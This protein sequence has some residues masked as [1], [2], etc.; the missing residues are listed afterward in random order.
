MADI[1]VS[2]ILILFLLIFPILR[3]FFKFLKKMPAVSLLPFFAIILGILLVFGQGL[4]VSILPVLIFSVLVFFSEIKRIVRFFAGLTNEFYSVVSIVFRAFL[5]ILWGLVFFEIVKFSPENAYAVT[6]KVETREVIL[7]DSFGKECFGGFFAQPDNSNVENLPTVLVMPSFKHTTSDISTVARY[8]IQEKYPVI[9]IRDICK[10]QP[11]YVPRGLDSLKNVFQLLLGNSDIEYIDEPEFEGFIDAVLE[12]YAS[13]KAVFVFSEGV[14]NKLITDYAIK[15][16][17]KIAGTF[18][19]AS[20]EYANKILQDI[21]ENRSIRMSADE[22]AKF[23]PEVALKPVCLFV[24]S[25]K[26]NLADMSELRGDDPLAAV[27]LGSSRSIGRSDLI[28]PAKVF[29][30]WIYVRGNYETK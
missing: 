24:D 15:N 22:G 17:S 10:K 20:E 12:K 23:L 19:Y 8:F 3:P 2:E 29:E 1:F 26:T 7:S 6:Q 4:Y 9:Q 18:V 13:D 16:P 25:E 5:L 28:K 21:T 14:Y 11:W 27:I 30:K